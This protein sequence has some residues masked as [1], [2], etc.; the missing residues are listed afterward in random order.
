MASR[1]LLIVA[2][3]LTTLAMRPLPQNQTA[4]PAP[5]PAPTAAIRGRIFAADTGRPLRRARVTVWAPD[6]DNST[7]TASTDLDGHYEIKELPAASYL[8]SVSRSG[9]L[10][11]NYGQRRPFEQGTP[12]RVEDRQLVDNVD[13]QLPHMSSVGGVITDEVGESISG[14]RVFLMRSSYFE[15]RRR[16]VP[17]GGNAITDEAGQYRILNVPPGT[18]YLMA[19]LRDTWTITEN[20]VD[21]TVAYAPTYFPGTNNFNEARRV[22]VGIGQQFAGTDFSMTPG[23]AASISGRALDSHLRP[24]WGETVYVSQEFRSLDG[25]NE[26]RAGG[27]APVE[28]DGTFILKNLPPGEYKLRMHVPNDRG[29]TEDMAT[30]VVV[31][32]INVTDVLLMTSVGWS[33]TGQIVAESGMAPT[34]APTRVRMAARLV[35]GDVD[36]R[37]GG[38]QGVAQ[39]RDDWTFSLANVFGAARLR[40]NL[41]DGWTVEA[42][43][44]NG[45]D[46]ADQILEAKSGEQLAGVQVVV[47]NRVTQ[48]LGQLTDDRGAPLTDGTIIVFSSDSE[49]WAEDSRFVRAARPDQQGQFRIRN[50]PAGEYLAV[51]ITYVPDGMW[52]DPEY[53]ESIRRYGQKLTLTEGSSQAVALKLTNP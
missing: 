33:M 42:V 2:A 43:L 51:A 19:M 38:N 13:F 31:N 4:V 46:I 53:L 50:L 18:Y 10:S 29:P 47:A 16:L 35:S 30:T 3:S 27:D 25:R 8:V 28:A 37:T 22:T 20:G 21:H 52:N 45:R 32:G 34:F 23:G 26:V 5:L 9:Y 15:G 40:V 48:V 17:V 49:K 12:L 36:P 24:L 14:V 41:P 1:S 44:Y 7:H 39:V 11:L 6:L